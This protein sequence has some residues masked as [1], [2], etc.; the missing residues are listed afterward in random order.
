MPTTKQCRRRN[1]AVAGIAHAEDNAVVRNFTCR[2]QGLIPHAVVRN[3]ACRRRSSGQGS[4]ALERVRCNTSFGRGSQC[5]TCHTRRRP[6]LTE[7]CPSKLD[8]VEIFALGQ[9]P[10]C[11]TGGGCVAREPACDMGRVTGQVHRTSSTS[12]AAAVSVSHA[13]EHCDHLQ[14][15]APEL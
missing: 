12:T 5:V 2:S 10:K 8:F 11:P 4:H 13:G 6:R 7:P 3:F 15:P 14:L 9:N 1:S